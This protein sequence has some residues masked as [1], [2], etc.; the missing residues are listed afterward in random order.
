MPTDIRIVRS[1]DF[2]KVTAQGEFDFAAT[3]RALLEVAFSAA[4]LSK[5]VVL[6]DTREAHALLTDVQLW[7]L[8]KEVQDHPAAFGRKT[9]ILCRP[10]RIDSAEFFALCAENRGAAVQAFTS[11]EKAMNWLTG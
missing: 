6:V 2:V 10:E 8:A 1:A 3:R 9:A 7:T 11:F 4:S 5:Y